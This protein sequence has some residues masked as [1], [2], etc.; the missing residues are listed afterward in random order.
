MYTEWDTFIWNTYEYVSLILLIAS[1]PAA[2]EIHLNVFFAKC[3]FS[4][5]HFSMLIAEMYPMIKDHMVWQQANSS[6]KR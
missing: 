1:D 3:I 5:I 4:G 6:L 2:F